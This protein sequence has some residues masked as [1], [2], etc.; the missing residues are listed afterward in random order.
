MGAIATDARPAAASPIKS[1]Q[2]GEIAFETATSGFTETVTI[3]SVDMSKTAVH[4]LTTVTGWATSGFS[5]ILSVGVRL[6][7]PTVLTFKQEGSAFRRD[8]SLSY[9]VIEYL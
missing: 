3:T 6:T 9:E 1:I 2:R 7:S 8:I 4:F 5:R